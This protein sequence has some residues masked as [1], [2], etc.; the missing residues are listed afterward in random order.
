MRAVFQSHGSLQ[1]CRK[2][3]LD[4]GKFELLGV[5]VHEKTQKLVS[6]FWVS[7]QFVAVF[8]FIIRGT[9]SNVSASAS[10]LA[11]WSLVASWGAESIGHSMP[12]V[13]SFHNRLRS[14]SG[15]Q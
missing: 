8:F 4:N 7:V 12:T 10:N 9:Q 13:G 15:Y 1:M 5:L 3:V 14:Y 6:N 2:M 11:A